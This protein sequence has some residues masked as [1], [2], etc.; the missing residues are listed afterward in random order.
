MIALVFVG[1]F[2][3]RPRALGVCASHR[4]LY[5]YMSNRSPGIYQSLN[6]ARRA[7]CNDG[8]IDPKDLALRP[9]CAAK[10]VL[11]L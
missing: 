4:D 8:I 10:P 2:H 3:G 11:K 7:R 1:P 6:Q 9:E 5:S